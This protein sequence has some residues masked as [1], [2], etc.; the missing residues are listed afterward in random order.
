MSHRGWTSLFGTDFE[1]LSRRWSITRSG[2]AHAAATSANPL[3]RRLPFKIR[4][5]GQRLT[6]GL[7]CQKVHFL[8]GA[9]L[10]GLFDLLECLGKRSADSGYR[11]RRQGPEANQKSRCWVSESVGESQRPDQEATVLQECPHRLI[12][13]KLRPQDRDMQPCLG[14]Q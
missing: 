6:E 3:P 10:K 7:R 5:R 2:G 1:V 14:R 12:G 11:R 8:S 9:S 13:R 4:S